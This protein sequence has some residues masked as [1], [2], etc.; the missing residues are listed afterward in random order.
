MAV[1]TDEIAERTAGAGVTVDGLLIKDGLLPGVT[2]ADI[3]AEVA[4]AAAAV[5]GNLDTHTGDSTIH[6][7]QAAISI[8]PSQAGAA[9]VSHTHPISQISDAGATGAALLATAT[10]ADG[11][12]A[13]GLGTMAT[14]TATNYHPTS[15]FSAA[16]TAA[17]PLKA[18]GTGGLRLKTAGVGAAQH[19]GSVFS[20]HYNAG[21][22]LA[23][24]VRES[25]G[26]AFWEAPGGFALGGGTYPLAIAHDGAAAAIT[27]SVGELRIYN[28]A[29]AAIRFRTNNTARLAIEDTTITASV[30]ITPASL[31]DAAAPNGTLYYSTT[32]S[33]LVFKD[34][35]GTV[36]NLY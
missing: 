19:S 28:T 33:K 3:G 8:A 4:G 30:S 25:D 36:N 12:T 1:I 24:F 9:A 20:V 31:A 10:Q 27:N 18:N 17:E 22:S 13:L 7:T 14:E 2:P 32:A 29:A 21:A 34:S 11:R 16:P 15:A 35:G 5:Q 26:K 23:M 6:F